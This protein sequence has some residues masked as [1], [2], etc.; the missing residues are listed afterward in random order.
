DA[1]LTQSNNYENN[2][3]Q[4]CPEDNPIRRIMQNR[5]TSIFVSPFHHTTSFSNFSTSKPKPK[6]K[7]NSFSPRETI[8][9][10]SIT[11]P[12]NVTSPRSKSSNTIIDDSS[13][14]SGSY[15]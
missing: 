4:L 5:T 6:T 14:R 2:Q 8:I 3:E 9:Q 13:L 12:P 10:S 15:P 7:N 1:N 11:I